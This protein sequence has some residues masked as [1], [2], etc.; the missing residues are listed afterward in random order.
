MR[1]IVAASRSDTDRSSL[2]TAATFPSSSFHFLEPEEINEAKE[3][4]PIKDDN[5]TMKKSRSAART[6]HPTKGNLLK[7]KDAGKASIVGRSTSPTELP[8]CLTNEAHTKSRGRSVQH[9]VKQ[10]IRSMDL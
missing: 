4:I 9:R 3:K 2:S 8:G 7:K 5:A 10:F 1:R 6:E